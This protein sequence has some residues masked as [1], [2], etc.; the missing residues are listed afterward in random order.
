MAQM[1]E[2]TVIESYTHLML[3]HLQEL[4]P[5]SEQTHKTTVQVLL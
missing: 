3:S 5:M 4:G 1:V 2:G